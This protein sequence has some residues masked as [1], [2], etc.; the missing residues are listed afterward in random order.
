VKLWASK[1]RTPLE[2][3]NN[4]PVKILVGPKGKPESQVELALREPTMYELLTFI[5][6][7][8]GSLASVYSKQWARD[9]V[10]KVAKGKMDAG[11]IRLLTPAFEPICGF[12]ATCADKPGLKLHEIITPAQF[13]ECINAMLFLVDAEDMALNFSRAL[14]KVSAIAKATKETKR[15]S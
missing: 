12:I 7:S 14:A 11:N 13:T 8:I 9:M 10:G 3:I 1:K 15:A 2:V 6:G 5:E 4:I